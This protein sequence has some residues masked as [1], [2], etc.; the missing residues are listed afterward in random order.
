[1][2]DQKRVNGNIVS[3]ASLKLKIGNEVFFGFTSIA[4]GD[5]RERVKAYGM[6][7]HHAPRGRSAGKYTVDPVKL[8]G[9]PGTIEA[10]REFLARNSTD[11]ISIG[12][13][14]FDAQLQY[15]E[16]GSEP[17]MNVV[18]ERCVLVTDTSSHEENPDPLKEEVELDCML[19]RRNGRVLFDA[20]EGSP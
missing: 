10:F 17:P 6:G 12:N 20:T 13:V 15:I 4:Y 9:P 1:M 14:E 3:W 7:R 11:G 8:G 5:K 18:L 2:S 19:I 16:R